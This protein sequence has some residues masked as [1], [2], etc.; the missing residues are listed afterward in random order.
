[1]AGALHDP[2][3]LILTHPG[4]NAAGRV[5]VRPL[6]WRE[7]EA[8]GVAGESSGGSRSGVTLGKHD[9]RRASL[10][11]DPEQPRIAPNPWY[12]TEQNGKTAG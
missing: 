11:A 4:V 12:R 1:M 5:M 9:L 10:L 3:A 7:A 8:P 6:A 2:R